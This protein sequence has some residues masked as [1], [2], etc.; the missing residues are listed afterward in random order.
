[1]LYTKELSVEK[2]LKMYLNPL[3]LT[4]YITDS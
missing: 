4:K 3:L 2:H 1:M